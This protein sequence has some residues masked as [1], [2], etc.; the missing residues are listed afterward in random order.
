MVSEHV[1]RDHENVTRPKQRLYLKCLHKRISSGS[2]ENMTLKL[3]LGPWPS[4]LE[5]HCVLT[6]TIPR[7]TSVCLEAKLS[8][9][10]FSD[11]Q[12]FSSLANRSG[13]SVHIS[14]NNLLI[15]LFSDF[16]NYLII[17]IFKNKTKVSIAKSE[18]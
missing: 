7:V 6:D 9:S 12:Q 10:V 17:L 3:T 18:A 2:T 14:W 8:P 1:E 4:V 11:T 16:L 13:F 15:L 5:P